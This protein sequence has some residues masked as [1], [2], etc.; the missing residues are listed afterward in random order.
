[1][2][3]LT[4]M[5]RRRWNYFKS[6]ENYIQIA[7]FL[8]TIIFVSGFSNG[9]WCAP[10]WQWQIGALAVFLAWFNTIILLSDLPWVGIPINMLFNIIFSFLKLI[11]LPILLIVAFAIPFYMVFVRDIV[12]VE[13]GAFNYCI[14]CVK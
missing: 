1:M 5:F 8:F 10:P 6:F 11:F 3:E 9:C 7:L 2:D 4:Q 13:V 12:A 14:H